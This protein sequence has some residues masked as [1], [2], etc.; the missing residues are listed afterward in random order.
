MSS[1]RYQ[2]TGVMLRDLLDNGAVVRLLG[3][4][5]RRIM[6][7]S[8]LRFTRPGVA[9]A[10]TTGLALAAC[11]GP[12]ST[13]DTAG[14]A[15]ASIATLWWVMLAGA[16]LLFVLVAALLL[17]AFVLP[18]AGA[19][20]RPLVWLAGGGLV[21][22]GVVL[23]PLLFYALWSGERLLAHPLPGAIRIEA[24]ARQWQW[25]FT[26][27]DA[28][29]GTRASQ[30][31]LHVPAGRPVD[32]RITSVDVIHSFWVPRLAGKIDAIPGHTNV[33]RVIA[34]RPGLYRGVCAEFC[35]T[36]HTGMEVLVEAHPADEY[37]G[38][39]ARLAESAP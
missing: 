33:L 3:F 18:G 23:T 15:A 36:G 25:T 32:L 27:F 39:I 11:S 26:Y 29:S 9:C 24:E 17:A 20:T 21:L 4:L 28:A 7:R 19:R 30:N 37:A 12:L 2:R 38:R 16:T 31:V 13:L 35:G 5:H 10:A 14:P 34:E 6:R 22:P 1:N 8:G